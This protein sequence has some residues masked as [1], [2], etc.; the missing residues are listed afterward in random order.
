MKML[1]MVALIVSTL[2]GLGHAHADLETQ[3]LPSGFFET[4]DRFEKLQIIE[5]LAIHSAPAFSHEIIAESD[6]AI[7]LAAVDE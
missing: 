2:C 7:S 4:T 3:Q 5:Q 1:I 6:S